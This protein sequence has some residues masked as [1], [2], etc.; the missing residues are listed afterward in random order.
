MYTSVSSLAMS[1]RLCLVR[2]GY[3]PVDPKMRREVEALVDHGFEVHLVCLRG[4]GQPPRERLGALDIYRLPVAHKRAGMVRYVFQYVAF[5]L[6]AR[7]R[8]IALHLRHR[9]TVVQV[10]TIPDFRVFAVFVPKLMGARLILVTQELMPSSSHRSSARLG[11]PHR[12]SDLGGRGRKHALCRSRDRGQRTDK[13]G[14]HGAWLP[15]EKLTVVMNSAD[16]RIFRRPAATATA[17]ADPGRGSPLLLAHGTLTEHYGFG[18][19]AKRW[20][21]FGT[22]CPRLACVSSAREN[23]RLGSARSHA[24]SASTTSSNSLATGRLRR[25]GDSPRTRRYLRRAE[26]GDL[27]QRSC[28]PDQAHGGCGDGIPA[29]VARSRAV[30]AYLDGAMVKFFEPGD[31]DDL[32]QAVADLARDP[33]KA[34]AMAENT[35]ATFLAK[36]DWPRQMKHSYL[37][38]IDE[39]ARERR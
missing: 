34:S 16:D 28:R 39:L 13:D 4:G 38:V 17:T 18:T 37:A 15:G 22:F 8:V 10:N 9:Y 19:V 29:V 1:R 32:A 14:R 11:A 33:T 21:P 12:S 7:L 36:Y 25:W 26:R 27:L 2:Q 31:P 20:P 35:A 23:T 30:E 6:L 5:S 3:Y 24:N